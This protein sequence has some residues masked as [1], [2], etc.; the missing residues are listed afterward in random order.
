MGWS[1]GSEWEIDFDLKHHPLWMAEPSRTSILVGGNLAVPRLLWSQTDRVCSMEGSFRSDGWHS[2]PS[3][4]AGGAYELPSATGHG[5]GRTNAIEIN[6]GES[7]V[8]HLQ[9]VGN[10]VRHGWRLHDRRFSIRRMVQKLSRSPLPATAGSW[11]T[12]GGPGS[13]GRLPV[14]ARWLRST[15]NTPEAKSNAPEPFSGGENSTMGNPRISRRRTSSPHEDGVGHRSRGRP[16]AG[17]PWRPSTGGF[18]RAVSTGASAGGTSSDAE[19]AEES[20]GLCW[21]DI[22]CA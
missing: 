12:Y 16:E 15:A 21:N 22:I 17:L 5:T 11:R 14:T 13:P 2:R 6:G 3:S 8:D 19:H 18:R 1:Q 7:W 4:C 10:V 9:R 20:L